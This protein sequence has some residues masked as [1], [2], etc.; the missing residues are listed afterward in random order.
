[1]SV[2]ARSRTGMADLPLILDKALRWAGERRDR[3]RGY[4]LAAALLIFL[5][6]LYWAITSIPDLPSRLRYEPIL[7]LLAV[8]APIGVLLNAIELHAIS[9]I[10]GG[11]MRWR[12]ALEI[13][14]YSSAANMLPLPGGTIAKLAAMK[15]HGV[16]YGRGSIMIALTY[17]VWGGLAFLYS[18]GALYWLGQV[19]LAAVF[20]L[21]G[22]VLLGLCAAGFARFAQWRL[23]GIVALARLVSFPLE[24][25]RYMLAMMAIGTALDFAQ[26]S[27][28]VIASFVGSAAMIFPSGLGVGETVVALLA[29]AI[30]VDA[31]IGFLGA[32]IGR[33]VWMT[34]LTLMTGLVLIANRARRRS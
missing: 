25:L 24:A 28:L 32:A 11:P 27:V 33:A 12:T 5:G 26:G 3:L 14:L 21:A 10:A 4:G 29:T 31:A 18:A 6:G 9:R 34:G 19:R 16:G 2:S 22:I 8:G 13:S 7:A 20:V 1:M 30:A 15:G 23:V 17:A